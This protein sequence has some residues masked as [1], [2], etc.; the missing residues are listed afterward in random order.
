[1]HDVNTPFANR[2]G[3]R[4][5]DEGLLPKSRR[6]LS[7]SSIAKPA[8]IPRG[9]RTPRAP[10]SR[11]EVHDVRR[12]YLGGTRGDPVFSA[13]PLLARQPAHAFDPLRRAAL[14]G[15]GLP[16]L[17]GSR[18]RLPGSH[19]ALHGAVR[20][21][22]RRHPAVPQRALHDDHRRRAAPAPRHDGAGRHLAHPG[23]RPAARLRAAA[24]PTRRVRSWRNGRWRPERL[25][26]RPTRSGTA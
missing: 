26:S 22:A 21:A 16:L 17:R 13:R 8:I 5:G 14:A 6:C 19:R 15:G 9:A 2:R 18:L 20:L 4:A 12:R 3:R 24:R 25:S 10:A 11:R 23:R 7:R 1:M